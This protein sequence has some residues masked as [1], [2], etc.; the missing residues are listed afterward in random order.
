MPLNERDSFIDAILTPV[1]IL[2]AK[3]NKQGNIINFM[4]EAANEAAA[5]ALN[6]KK[7]F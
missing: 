1:I 7:M 4:V 2:K 6:K 3:K 5:I